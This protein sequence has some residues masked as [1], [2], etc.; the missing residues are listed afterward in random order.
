MPVDFDQEPDRIF[1]LASDGR[2][3]HRADFIILL[4]WV[5]TV[6]RI[7]WRRDSS[8]RQPDRHGRCGR[9]PAAAR[10][11][12][13]QSTRSVIKPTGSSS[14]PPGGPGWGVSRRRGEFKR[15][16]KSSS[17]C[18][19][20]QL[21]EV[22]REWV[23]RLHLAPW[24]MVLIL[25]VLTGT[26]LGLGLYAVNRYLYDRKFYRSLSLELS[27][28][29]LTWFA[30]IPRK[31]VFRTGNV[32]VDLNLKDIIRSDSRAGIWFT[33]LSGAEKITAGAHCR[34]LSAMENV[35]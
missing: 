6:S 35:S 1:E 12:E 26:V 8:S 7:L 20:F 25:I 19:G 29:K 4:I 30:K 3:A 2:D 14:A 5:L 31:I 10:K 13:A 34:L 32:G 28:V 11:V 33:T 23:A 21:S 15:C 24:Q 18:R 9:R 22:L 27:E 16:R 17:I